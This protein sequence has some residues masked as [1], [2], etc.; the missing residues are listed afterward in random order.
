MVS[1]EFAD[2]RPHRPAFCCLVVNEPSSY[3]AK[4]ALDYGNVKYVSISFP[5]TDY[6]EK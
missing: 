5:A 6:S 3:E 2:L 4:V 1:L